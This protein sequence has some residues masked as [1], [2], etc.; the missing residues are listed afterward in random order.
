LNSSAAAPM[1]NL[2]PVGYSDGGVGE[3]PRDSQLGKLSYRELRDARSQARSDERRQEAADP[4][5]RDLKLHNNW[6]VV[7]NV[8]LRLL[9]QT[10][11]DIE[12]MVWLCEAETRIAGHAGL[13][14]A[15]RRIADAVRLHG[16][17]LHP[18][19][20]PGE[21]DQ[22]TSL[23][24]LNGVGREGT[25][26]QPLRL[27]SLV[28]GFGYGEMSLW[29]VISG[30]GDRDVEKAM[31]AA[32]KPAMRKRLEEVIAAAE[33]VRDCDSATTELLGQSG[34][35]FSQLIDILDES[36]RTIRRLCGLETADPAPAAPT[37]ASEQQP[38]TASVQ[39]SITSREQALSELLRIA[40]YFRQTEPHSPLGDSLETLVRRGRMDFMSLISELIP[41][42]D[43]RQSLMTTAGIARPGSDPLKGD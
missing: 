11:L 9:A 34:P 27:L 5:A 39:G 36:A 4:E 38:F 25:L 16:S 23:A 40:E 6:S 3:N 42:P 41:D 28:P 29:H 7:Q 24:G 1:N 32:G 33:A 10:G 37:V 2:V 31:S 18:Q 12:V 15:M 14:R 26:V 8:A 20:D 13:A 17:A 30:T 22:F 19:P 43:A 21:D 35:P